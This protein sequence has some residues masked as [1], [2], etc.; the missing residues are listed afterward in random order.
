MAKRVV[1]TDD[2]TG[3]VMSQWA[4]GDEQSV[5]IVPGRTNRT[6]ALGDINDYAGYRWNGTAFEV[7][8]PAPV[9]VLSPC[10]FVRRFTLAEEVAIDTLSDTDRTVKIWRHRV[11]LSTSVN[12]D[13]ADVINGLAYLKSVSV[14][15]LWP[16][17]KRADQRIAEIRR[18][19]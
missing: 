15:S 5:G 4:G 3:N 1:T 8:P 2:V 16:T 7:I 12:L 13:H 6:L 18:S 17:T 19:A 11:W 14:P 9:R 10:E